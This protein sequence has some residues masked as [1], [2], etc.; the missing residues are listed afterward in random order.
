[1]AY[2]VAVVG[3]GHNGLICAAYLARAG[4]DVVVLEARSNIG[5]CSATVEALGARVNI[6]N[7]DHI[8]VRS[9][10]I[11]D[12]LDLERY[13][14]RYL[15]ADPAQLALPWNGDAPWFLFHD[16]ER[17]LESLRLSYPSEVE[18]YR[19]YLKAALPAARL[20]I[21]LANVLPTPLNVA[22]MLTRR[23]AA[24]VRTLLSWG[25]RSLDDVLRSFFMSDAL[26]SPAA[27]TGPAVAGLPPQF[28]GTGGAALGY[29]LRHL[30]PAGRPV[31]GSG[32]LTDALARALEASGGAVR[33]SACVENVLVE[34]RRVRGVTL[35][36][37]EEIAAHGVVVACD[38]RVPV[39][40][41][42]GK[43][44]PKA[45]TFERRRG[46]SGRDGYQSKLDAV[47]AELPRYRAVDPEAA[48]RLGVEE[49]LAPT[50]VVAPDVAALAGAHRSMGE[51]R[52]AARP[53]HLV[54]IPSVIDSSMRLT[55]GEHVLSLE[56][57]FTPYGLTESWAGNHAEPERWLEGFATLVE[58]GFLESVR[59]WRVVTPA[60]YES[61]F[62]QPRGQA[63]SYGL[64]P[65]ATVLGRE[66]DLTRYE[67]G[68]AGLFLTGVAT[69]P[70]GG[71]WG[72]PGR[73]A[74]AVVGR[75]LA[76]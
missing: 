66:R 47:I 72:A 51:G 10:P 28:P 70:G 20:V 25:R 34:G 69:Y 48:R 23:R 75:A 38:P 76:L 54:N 41:W 32:G 37:G 24:G 8:M 58:P 12:E 50:T 22:S 49:P 62:G 71:V 7:C 29:A 3:A 44:P 16:V 17:T 67:T 6:C 60:D 55:T 61:D 11:A 52:V 56:A 31:G 27:V 57:L 35:A 21:E 74:A 46:R 15:E 4:L 45:T 65:L 1:M 64:S 43:S 39:L 5:G 73:N 14:L 33:I 26:V 9:T 19:R 13:G 40:R 30:V 53:P 42:L 36:G 59:R 63:L 68:V 2:D 18:S